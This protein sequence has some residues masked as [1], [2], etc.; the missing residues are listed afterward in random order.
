MAGSTAT[1]SDAVGG[2]PAHGRDRGEG[3]K[4]SEPVVI[5]KLTA[6]AIS[7]CVSWGLGSSCEYSELRE[8]WYAMG[9]PCQ[10]PPLW[11]FARLTT[12]C[13]W[14]A[15]CRPEKDKNCPEG[16][17]CEYVADVDLSKPMSDGPWNVYFCRPYPKVS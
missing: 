4:V 10:S 11:F 6:L 12:S 9:Q 17:D 15:L 5:F 13:H 1:H 7:L 16:G 14:V 8:K 2:D 3:R